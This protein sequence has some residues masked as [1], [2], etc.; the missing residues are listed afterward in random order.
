MR[1]QAFTVARSQIE[2]VLEALNLFLHDDE[3]L[4]LDMLE[5]ETDLFGIVRRLLNDNEDDEGKIAA[6][7]Q[8]VED[9]K[10]RKD[11]AEHRI[12]K[13]KEAIASLME[14]AQ[15]AK[16]PLPEATLS[17]RRLEPRPKVVDAEALPDAFVRVQQVRKP[18]LEAIAA[19][20][21]QGATIPGVVMSN[22]GISL[23]TRRK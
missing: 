23:T 19:A 7:K 22:G 20:A 11:R 14:A 3:Q 21:E 8:Q 4:R 1:P 9:R 12:E 2:G 17:L 10:A 16:L 13:R 18:D 5:G 15:L 6:L